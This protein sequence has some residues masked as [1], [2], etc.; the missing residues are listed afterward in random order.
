MAWDRQIRGRP[1]HPIR[2]AGCGAY[3]FFHA[4]GARAFGFPVPR[5][6]SLSVLVALD[7]SVGIP[8][9]RSK[10]Q[11][12][13]QDGNSTRS[14]AD[15]HERRSNQASRNRHGIQSHL[16]SHHRRKSLLV[17]FLSTPTIIHEQAPNLYIQTRTPQIEHNQPTRR[18]AKQQPRPADAIQPTPSAARTTRT[19]GQASK[20]EPTHSTPTLVARRGGQTNERADDKT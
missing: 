7:G 4:M 19:M 12:E 6:F 1:A 9:H 15:T 11:T 8:S 10:I 16:V 2:R 20:N 5:G 13:G 18:H 14:Q 17:R 3:C